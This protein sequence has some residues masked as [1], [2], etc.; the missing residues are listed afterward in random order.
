MQLTLSKFSQL[1]LILSVDFKLLFRVQLIRELSM[2]KYRVEQYSTVPHSTAQHCSIV[3]HNTVY[4]IENRF[5]GIKMRFILS[6][7]SL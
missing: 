1:D 5:C 2:V 4:S 7:V 3:Y 6:V